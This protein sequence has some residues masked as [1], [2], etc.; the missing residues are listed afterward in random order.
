MSCWHPYCAVGV[1]ADYC[2]LLVSTFSGV[3]AIACLPF[4]VDVCDVPIVSAAVA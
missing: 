3:L 1:P 2:C 4:A